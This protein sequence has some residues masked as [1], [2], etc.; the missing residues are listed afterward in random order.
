[1]QALELRIG[2]FD[3]LGRAEVTEVLAGADWF[4]QQILIAV[5]EREASEWKNWLLTLPFQ[6]WELAVIPEGEA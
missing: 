1:M 6:N 3:A 2:G 4:G 5:P